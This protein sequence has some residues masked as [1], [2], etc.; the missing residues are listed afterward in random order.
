[1]SR[2]LSG[3]WRVLP[4]PASLA[5]IAARHVRTPE[6]DAALYAEFEA[7]HPELVAAFEEPD[8][9]VDDPSRGWKV[10]A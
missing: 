3:S 7:R 2:Q 10:G 8:D 9:F 6:T 5:L 4:F 1:V